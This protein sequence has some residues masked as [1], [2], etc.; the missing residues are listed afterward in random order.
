MKDPTVRR[1]NSVLTSMSADKSKILDEIAKLNKQSERPLTAL[2]RQ[3]V[4]GRSRNG[5][6][7]IGEME[8][9][10]ILDM[11]NGRVWCDGVDLMYDQFYYVNTGS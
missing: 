2:T 7:R 4:E 3:P 5:G 8:R 1:S 9:D 6:L 11:V 10:C